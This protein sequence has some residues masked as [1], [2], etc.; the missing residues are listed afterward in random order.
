M[1][2][3][4]SALACC[5]ALFERIQPFVDGTGRV[6]RILPSYLAV[7]QGY[8][9]IVI[10]GREPEQRTRYYTALEAADRG[11]HARFPLPLQEALHTQL[12]VE[13][14]S[15][16]TVLLCEGVVPRLD[17]L[18]QLAQETRA[19]LMDLAR[20]AERLGVSMAARRQRF[21]RGKFIAERRGKKLFS[22]PD[23]AFCC[24]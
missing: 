6:G 21:H 17:H 10:K 13:N 15:P 22:H 24:S 1:Q 12:A 2:P 20:I 8:P 16:L 11:F 3:I 14:I 5:H 4:L 23:L 19:P 18:I 9:P 7:I